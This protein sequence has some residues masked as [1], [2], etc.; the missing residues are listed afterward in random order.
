MRR[1]FVLL[2]LFMGTNF[3]Y[4]RNWN[5][6]LDSIYAIQK[7]NIPNSPELFQLQFISYDKLRRDVKTELFSNI[8]KRDTLFIIELYGGHFE[9]SYAIKWK[10]H[11]TDYISYGFKHIPYTK[12]D[13]LIFNNNR[14]ECLIPDSIMCLLERGDIE[15]VRQNTK[16][17]DRTLRTSLSYISF[18]RIIFLRKKYIISNFWFKI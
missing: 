15:T 7:I 5:H 14:E 1:S 6:I 11:K 2:L 16:K 12:R 10:R 18:T 8:D 17:K 3:V 4:T 13:T 9:R